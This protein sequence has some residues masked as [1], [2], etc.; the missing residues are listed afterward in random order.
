M[1]N[2]I[3]LAEAVSKLTE[4]FIS[5]K[6]IYELIGSDLPIIPDLKK[7][8]FKF[9][10]FIATPQSLCEK[11]IESGCSSQS[12]TISWIE[13][14]YGLILWKAYSMMKYFADKTYWSYNYIFNQL[15][16]R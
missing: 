4:A 12:L 6:E 9:E 14:H 8:I 5:T 2:R 16:Y 15:L 11:M 10:S 1:D 13:N 7:T 3:S